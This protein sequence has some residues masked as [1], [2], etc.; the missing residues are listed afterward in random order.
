MEDHDSSSQQLV[1]SKDRCSFTV[2]RSER[3]CQTSL[4]VLVSTLSTFST[5]KTLLFQSALT[6]SAEEV[7]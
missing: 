6:L 4:H 7:R 1:V 2:R 3:V 5:M